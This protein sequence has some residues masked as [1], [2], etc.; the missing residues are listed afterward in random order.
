MAYQVII[1]VANEEPIL[2]EVDTMPATTDTL[3]VALN[4]R[5]RDGKD[6]RQ[7]APNVTT[8]IWPMTRVTLIEIMPSSEEEMV[9]GPVRE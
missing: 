7:L 5:Q 3:I 1:H 8:A 9:V 4:P 2:A 6:L